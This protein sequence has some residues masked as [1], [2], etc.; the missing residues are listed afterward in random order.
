MTDRPKTL[1][2]GT[3]EWNALLAHNSGELAAFFQQ[4]PIP[5]AETYTHIVQHLDR[6][7]EIL[8]GWLATAQPPV[9]REQ[10]VSAP[11]PAPAQTNGAARRKGGWPKG[12]PRKRA[13]PAQAIQ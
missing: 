11:Q 4:Q 3:R 5:S 7:K 9:V 10:Q 12:K 1:A 6:M 2:L 8:P 13:A